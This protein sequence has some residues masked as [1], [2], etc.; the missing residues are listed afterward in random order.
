MDNNFYKNKKVF[1]TGHTGFKGS[2]LTLWLLSLGADV[3]GYSL[4]PP[5]SPNLFDVLKIEKKINHIIGNILDEEKLNKSLKETQPEIVFH[6]AAQA[7]VRQSYVEPKQTYQ[8][9]IIGTVNLFEAIRKTKSVKSV[10]IVTSDKCYENKEQNIAYEE[11]DAMGGYDPYSSS[12][13]CTELI[14]N[15][16]RNSFFNISDFGK[17]HNVAIAS[18]RAG[19]VIGGGDWA[20]DRLIPDCISSIYKNETINIRNPSAT[21]PWQ[22]VLEPLSGYLLLA[23]KLFTDGT[24]FSG[25][26]NLGP[27]NI[28][29]IEVETVVKKTIEILQKGEYKIENNNKFHEA[30]LLQLDIS[31]AK[32]KLNWKPTFHANQAIQYACDWYKNFYENENFNAFEFCLKQID[33]YINKNKI[34]N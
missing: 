26:W 1:I 20:K 32:T 9:N 11:T 6:L 5:T 34:S 12:K 27:E 30:N 15:S 17:K 13:G 21:R 3:T 29:V 4:E 16:Y 7:L 10:V 18:V 14:T 33:E 8:T 25:G 31:K 24:K 28:D 2:W 23:K 19:N 22:H